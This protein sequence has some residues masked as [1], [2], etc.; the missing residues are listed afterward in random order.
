MSAPTEADVIAFTQH[1]EED[2]RAFA[3]F[4]RDRHLIVKCRACDLE[5]VLATED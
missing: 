1:V 5:Q 4:V 3:M 2:G